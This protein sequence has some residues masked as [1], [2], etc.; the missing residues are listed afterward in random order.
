M[1]FN[2]D[3][4]VVFA[5]FIIIQSLIVVLFLNYYTSKVGIEKF[6]R[7]VGKKKEEL[8]SFFTNKIESFEDIAIGFDIDLE[9]Y[10]QL[11]KKLEFDFKK[12]N[13]SQLYFSKI[14]QEFDRKIKVLREQNN[15][16]VKQISKTQETMNEIK[17]VEAA[18]LANEKKIDKL[19]DT[20]NQFERLAIDQENKLSE[21][22]K[23]NVALVEKEFQ[24]KTDLAFDK[25]EEH[26]AT[27]NDEIKKSLVETQSLLE[28]KLSSTKDYESNLRDLTEKKYQSLIVDAKN[29]FDEA[30]HQEK[31]N[32]KNEI[33]HL[34]KVAEEK[35]ITFEANLGIK[36]EKQKEIL[37]KQKEMENDLTKRKNILDEEINVLADNI[38]AS[39]K[40]KIDEYQESIT[41]SLKEK[42]FQLS[43]DMSKWGEELGK[44]EDKVID[45]ID[46]KFSELNEK[47]EGYK[48]EISQEVDFV[49]TN[50][51]EIKN[52]VLVKNQ[53]LVDESK[54]QIKRLKKEMKKLEDNFTSKS[55]GYENLLELIDEAKKN[56]FEKINLFTDFLDQKKKQGQEIF[57]HKKI[58]LEENYHI[59]NEEINQYN[60]K[61]TLIEH[62][63]QELNQTLTQVSKEHSASLKKDFQHHSSALQKEYLNKIN[64]FKKEYFDIINEKINQIKDGELETQLSNLLSQK[65]E[66]IEE[67]SSRFL[68]FIQKE[69]A[70]TKQAADDLQQKSLIEIDQVKNSLSLL[71]EGLQKIEHKQ[72]DL[73]QTLT[74]VSNEHSDSLKK[75]FQHHSSSLQKEYLNKINEF[76]KQH[77]DIINEKINLF[78][79]EQMTYYADLNEVGNKKIADYQNSIL[80]ES[81]SYIENEIEKV[82]KEIPHLINKIE[83][84]HEKKLKKSSLAIEKKVS[85]WANSIE[86]EKQKL[87]KKSSDLNKINETHLVKLLN[88]NKNLLYDLKESDKKLNQENKL[89]RENLNQITHLKKVSQKQ[90]KTIDELINENKKKIISQESIK[91]MNLQLRSF[92]KKIFKQFNDFLKEQNLKIEKK[93]EESSQ[94]NIA[95]IKNKALFKNSFKKGK[96]DKKENFDQLIHQINEGILLIDQ[97]RLKQEK[98]IDT[99]EKQVNELIDYFKVKI[100]NSEE[101]LVSDVNYKIKEVDENINGLNKKVNEFIKNASL[102]DEIQFFE[103]KTKKSLEEYSNQIAI[104]KK[105][106][107]DFN[108]TKQEAKKIKKSITH[109]KDLGEV[110]QSNKKELQDINQKINHTL[111]TAEKLNNS[112]A[113]IENERKEINYFLS[114]MKNHKENIEGIKKELAQVKKYSELGKALNEKMK[115][116][117]KQNEEIHEQTNVVANKIKEDNFLQNKINNKLKSLEDKS[118][119][120][121]NNYQKMNEFSDKY[122]QL[123]LAILDL[124]KRIEKIDKIKSDLLKEQRE[125]LDLKNSFNEQISLALEFFKKKNEGNYLKDGVKKNSEMIS[126]IKKLDNIGWSE[127]EIAHHLEI[128]V[129]EVRLILKSSEK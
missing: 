125:M 108:K 124:E 83:I 62:K 43:N 18:A 49:T 38:L 8:V 3:L 57:N 28:E 10:E 75:D 81:K 90:L 25:L 100:K 13:D 69:Q 56:I 99:K 89:F 101:E 45:Q 55:N 19:F 64:D 88:E 33:T 29:S 35:L 86:Q 129:H 9:R 47:L 21:I 66:L 110:I 52:T 80:Q 12:L 67:S 112:I 30:I 74:Q 71:N 72:Q 122:D 98:F 91:K 104:I 127:K 5:T 50:Q 14:F 78:F 17:G 84:K 96:F 59:F 76:K 41:D 93:I 32:L 53:N 128:N 22:T 114:E 92:E 61:L 103:K 44:K 116:A 73:N 39:F 120:L 65:K 94:K 11:K 34:R 107:L 1:D 24:K 70:Q 4:I 106:L 36:E 117:I 105:D 121:E 60:E 113:N 51:N 87:L 82:K 95:L 15:A 26:L 115:K 27:K 6:S 97:N 111:V 2:L 109:I 58:S 68:Y 7:Y 126:T 23:N 37:A 118:L 63:Q 48:K 123:D 119:I 42:Y 46:E 77:F 54:E 31:E 16:F 40:N 79:K 102:I 85:S 20:I